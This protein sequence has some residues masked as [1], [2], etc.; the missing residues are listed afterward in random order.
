MGGGRDGDGG[1]K[2]G[3]KTKKCGGKQD[4]GHDDDEEEDEG[5]E[6]KGGMVAVVSSMTRLLDET[7]LSDL[8]RYWMVGWLVIHAA[9][10]CLG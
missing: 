2:G 1:E 8:A 9:S 7:V 4:K 10:R 6:G 5:E 3:Q